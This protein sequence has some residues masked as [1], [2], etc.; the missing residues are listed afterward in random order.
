MG[1]EVYHHLKSVIQKKYGQDGKS[2]IFKV[3]NVCQ[4]SE[5]NDSVQQKFSLELLCNVMLSSFRVLT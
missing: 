2:F 5:L 3:A 4:F 1:S